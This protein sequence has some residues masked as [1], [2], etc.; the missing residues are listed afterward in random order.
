MLCSLISK[1][2]VVGLKPFIADVN[3][4][5]LAPTTPWHI[6]QQNR[7]IS[8]AR[9]LRYARLQFLEGTIIR[10]PPEGDNRPTAYEAF[11]FLNLV[12]AS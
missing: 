12:R 11:R 4:Q 5:T 6:H 1:V 3:T 2:Y 10:Q 9:S 7:T 8:P